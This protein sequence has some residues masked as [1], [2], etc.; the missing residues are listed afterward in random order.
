VLKATENSKGILSTSK[1][2]SNAEG[3][4]GEKK[5]GS[6]DN[7][8]SKLV[9]SNTL[10]RELGKILMKSGTPDGPGWVKPYDCQKKISLKK[11]RATFSETEGSKK[12]CRSRGQG[13]GGKCQIL[14]CKDYDKYLGDKNLEVRGRKRRAR[15]ELSEEKNA[16]CEG[17]P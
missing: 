8:S 2:F 7:G 14:S 11:G 6:Q 3:E 17:L 16:S 5:G 15:E 1:P 13:R 4:K 12:N 10:R 9:Y